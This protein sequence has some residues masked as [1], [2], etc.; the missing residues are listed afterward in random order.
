MRVL[1]KF[2]ISY[3]FVWT[4]EHL[5]CIV[6]YRQKERKCCG[7]QLE[8]DLLCVTPSHLQLSAGIQSHFQPLA[9]LL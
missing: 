4:L 3:D 5:D 2:E 8:K 6:L 7:F 9:W 1:N